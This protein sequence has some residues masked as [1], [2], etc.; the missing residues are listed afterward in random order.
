MKD[1]TLD[2]LSTITKLKTVVRSGWPLRGVPNG[3][4]VADHSFQVAIMSMFLAP[5]VGVDQNK[6]VLMAL[7]H[8]IG[9]SIIGDEITERGGFDLPNLAQKQADE[10]N[11]VQLIFSRAGM[12]EYLD[13][14][15]EFVANETPEAQFVRQ[16]DKLEAAIQAHEY[17]KSSGINLDEFYISARK[18]VSN[19]VLVKL[20]DDVTTDCN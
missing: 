8:D 4:S 12:E 11:A 7:I 17:A 3:E 1:D 6:S 10:R 2:F 14:F 15:D 16:L 20:L 18:Q 13:L 9:E 19:P 5:K